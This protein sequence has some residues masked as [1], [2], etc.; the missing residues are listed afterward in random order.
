M[1]DMKIQNQVRLSLA[2]TFEICVNG[3]YYRLFRS[4]V[5]VSIV[6]VAIAFMMYMLGGSVIGKAVN[7]HAGSEARRYKVYDRWLSWIDAGMSRTSLFR[8]LAACGPDDS[9]VRSMAKW[10]RLSEQQVS[11]LLTNANEGGRYLQFYEDLTP[12]KRFMLAE[13]AGDE[14][15][16][17]ALLD[18][19]AFQQFTD[20][21]KNLPSLRLPGSIEELRALLSTY[22]KQIPIWDS[23]ETGRNQAIAELRARYP[24]MTAAQLL[25]SPPADFTATLSELGFLNDSTDLSDA[26]DGALYAQR[27]GVLAGLLR[28]TSLKR[29]ISKRKRID[30]TMVNIDV[31]AEIYLARGGPEFLDASLKRNELQLGFAS[32]IAHQVFRS[33]LRRN[34]ILQ[35][36]SVT[37]GFS[38]GFLGF[39]SRTLWLLGVSFIV[40]VVGIANAMLMS[41]MERFREIATMKCLGA[42][43][44]FVMILFVLE[45][46]MQGVVGGLV[47]AVL[48]MALSL[49]IAYLNYGG[50]VWEVLPLRD[51]LASGLVA[52]VTGILLAAIASVYPA[53]VAAKLVPM[54]AMRVE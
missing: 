9:Q 49:P 8:I 42:T 35:I 33:H 23:I 51:I 17:D 1:K 4:I 13:L 19:Q 12:G 31:L 50:L 39:S 45:S 5:T 3:I 38:E 2:R 37:A 32:D 54:E 10:G 20:R 11:D 52:L 29:D 26:R 21:L 7:R 40:C 15:L 41:V 46:C 34:R 24:G 6:S 25:A 14:S 16:L 30:S 43:D 47:G 48:G 22:Q 53:H 28:N 36:A 44:S 18:D 27:L